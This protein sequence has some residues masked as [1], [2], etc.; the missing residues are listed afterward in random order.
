LLGSLRAG[1]SAIATLVMATAMTA[2]SN[3]QAEAPA[4]SGLFARLREISANLVTAWWR[5]QS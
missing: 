1:L 4:N 3:S 5:R 2:C